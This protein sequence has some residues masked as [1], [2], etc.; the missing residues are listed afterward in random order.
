M[1]HRDGWNAVFLDRSRNTVAA[2]F[3]ISEHGRMKTSSVEGL[4]GVDADQTLLKNVN[5]LNPSMR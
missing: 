3:N 2:Q 5:L 1:S 4:D